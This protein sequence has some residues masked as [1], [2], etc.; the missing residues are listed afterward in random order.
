MA[1]NMNKLIC[2]VTCMSDY[3]QRLDWGL[4]LLT[5]LPQN[6]KLKIITAP[7]LIF[8]LYTSQEHIIQCSQPVTRRFLVTALTMDI[9]LPPS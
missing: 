5:T 9:S 2:F 4:A 6:S 7:P 1:V 3:R 8:T